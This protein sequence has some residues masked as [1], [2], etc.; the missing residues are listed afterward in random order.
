[1]P[2]PGRQ[3]QSLRLVRVILSVAVIGLCAWLLHTMDLRQVAVTLRHA[4]W[5]LILL[6]MAINVGLNMVARATRW[7]LLV[8][9]LPHRGAGAR[10]FELWRLL[11][12]AFALSN[13]VP[14]RAGEA[15]R[16]MALSRRHGYPVGA[17]IAAQFFEKILEC[18]SLVLLALPAALTAQGASLARP[19]ALVA[20][21]AG[22]GAIIVLVI[23]A[24]ARAR[25]DAPVAAAPPP[26][27]G[28]HPLARLGARLR[29]L[30]GH[31]AGAMRLLHSPRRW[32][33]GLGLSVCADLVDATMIGL[34][35]TAVGIHLPVPVWFFILLALNLAIAVP[36]T[37]GQVGVLEAGVVVALIAFGV[38]KSQALAFALLYHASHVLPTVALGVPFMWREFGSP[39]RAAAVGLHPEAAAAEEPDAGRA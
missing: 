25:G 4:D 21:A 36:S 39:R 14:A 1:M 30:V 22:G 32:A 18:A 6:A 7:A 19:V 11:L 24:R 2:E 5:R 16:F 26:S 35:L 12:A 13:L 3:S 33:A 15:L 10:T 37:P 29:S 8:A 28:F 31:L 9:P 38:P 27:P 23:A 34:A 20:A 17:L